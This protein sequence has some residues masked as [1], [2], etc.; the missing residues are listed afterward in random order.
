M[1]SKRVMSRF[2]YFSEIWEILPEFCKILMQKLLEICPKKMDPLNPHGGNSP[3]T[4]PA[5]NAFDRKSLGYTRRRCRD[6]EAKQRRPMRCVTSRSES[7]LYSVTKGW[8]THLKYYKMD[9]N[10]ISEMLRAYFTICFLKTW[11]STHP[12]HLLEGQSGRKHLP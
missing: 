9:Q 4:L 5:S 12:A 3:S 2:S 7:P 6:P 10:A 8:G 1:I 11:F